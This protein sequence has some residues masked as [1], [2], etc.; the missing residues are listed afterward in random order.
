MIGTKIFYTRPWVICG[1]VSSSGGHLLVNIS[2]VYSN[3][4]NGVPT[5]VG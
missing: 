5:E 3:S 4:K 2:D 1:K